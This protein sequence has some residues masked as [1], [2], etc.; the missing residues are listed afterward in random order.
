MH[1]TSTSHLSLSSMATPGDQLLATRDDIDRIRMLIEALRLGIQGT[2]A[3]VAELE[4]HVAALDAAIYQ[5]NPG[6]A[7]NYLD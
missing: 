5:H 1:S 6:P 4:N 7:F 3:R 2:N